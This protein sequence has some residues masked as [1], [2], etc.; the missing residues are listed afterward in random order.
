VAPRTRERPAGHLARIDCIPFQREPAGQEPL[1]PLR[2]Q[3]RVTKEIDV[4]RDPQ[5]LLGSESL[6]AMRTCHERQQSWSGPRRGRMRLLGT[7]RAHWTVVAIAWVAP[8][9]GI[10]SIESRRGR[11]TCIVSR[12]QSLPAAQGIDRSIPLNMARYKSF[13]KQIREGRSVLIAR[14]RSIAHQPL[15]N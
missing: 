2:A 10:R 15:Y 4:F 8:T 9:Q 5:H 3:Q 7:E 11:K 12:E 14:C 13:Q 1:L 6:P